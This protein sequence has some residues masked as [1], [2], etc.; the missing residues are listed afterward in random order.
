MIYSSGSKIK[1]FAC[2]SNRSLAEAIAKKVGLEMGRFL[3]RLM[4]QSA[5]QMFTLFSPR[6]TLSMIT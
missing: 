1:I 4:K 2:N 6:L 3:S 5:A